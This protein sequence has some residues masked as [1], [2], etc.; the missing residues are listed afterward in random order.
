M[1]ERA[2]G[3]EVNVSGQITIDPPLNHQ[4][5]RRAR[6]LGLI[7]HDDGVPYDG[8]RDVWIKVADQVVETDQGTLI[9]REASAIIPDENDFSHDHMNDQLAEIVAAFPDRAYAGFLE[10]SSP[11]DGGEKWR[12]AIRDG[13]VVDLFPVMTWPEGGNGIT[14]TRGQLEAWAGRALT[15]GEIER[16]DQCLP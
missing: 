4:D 11:D 1:K 16:L 12:T 15:D 7:E 2:M 13:L 9:K 10:C 5:V 14:L 3:S 8:Q 6:D